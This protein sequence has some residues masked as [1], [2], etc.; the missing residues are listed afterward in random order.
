M[1]TLDIRR[2]QHKH[3]K[4][5]LPWQNNFT[6]KYSQGWGNPSRKGSTF[7]LTCTHTTTIKHKHQGLDGAYFL[8]HQ[9]IQWTF[10]INQRFSMNTPQTFVRV[11]ATNLSSPDTNGTNKTKQLKERGHH[12]HKEET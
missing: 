1:K 10:L 5:K 6:T 3:T 2:S 8:P 4:P 11:S 9:P 7:P 12:L